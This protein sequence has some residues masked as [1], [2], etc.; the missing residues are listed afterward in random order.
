MITKN[1]YS[2][3][4]YQKMT[5]EQKRNFY[6][7]V[8]ATSNKTKNTSVKYKTAERKRKSSAIPEF[9]SRQPEPTGR[10]TFIAEL[11]RLDIADKKIYYLCLCDCGNWCIVR[12][13][14][15]NK[16][17][18]GS[19]NGG[20]WSCGCLNKENQEQYLNSP[21]YTKNRAIGI[22]KY[23]QE[24]GI[25]VQI[26]DIVNGW[27]I[28]DTEIRT[29]NPNLDTKSRRYIKGICPCCQQETDKWI[30]LDGIKN[31]IVLSC[32]CLDSN[33]SYLST[34]IDNILQE[35]NYKVIKEKTFEDCRFP[36]SNRLARFD[37]WVND[38][39]IIEY[40][41]EQHFKPGFGISEAEYK[42]Y[43]QRDQYKTNW[44]ISHK[45]PLIRIPYYHKD[46]TIN[47]L[48]PTEDNPWLITKQ[49]V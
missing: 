31:G 6:E 13:D 21:E 35:N 16:K 22:Q 23:Y 38:Q 49:T 45:I 43:Q 46:I 47:D 34:V 20:S 11:Q 32:G 42:E 27:V 30:R 4:D 29:V 1:E 28:T 18:T 12:Q 15:Y 3:E 14:T 10:L 2:V 17:R 44:C 37:F 33:R 24:A 7:L 48:I 19:R 25:T 5:E 8:N 9:Y 26:G 36:N 41:G 40:D 39:Y